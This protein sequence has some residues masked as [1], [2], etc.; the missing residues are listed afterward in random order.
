MIRELGDVH[1]YKFAFHKA[2]VHHIRLGQ[3]LWSEIV[4]KEAASGEEDAKCNTNSSNC[5]LSLSIILC[6]LGEE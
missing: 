2:C 6:P 4:S 3:Y 1:G 5:S